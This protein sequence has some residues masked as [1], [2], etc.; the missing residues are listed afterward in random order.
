M[1]WAVILCFTQFGGGSHCLNFVEFRDTAP[2][3]GSEEKLL[4]MCPQSQSHSAVWQNTNPVLSA[5][6]K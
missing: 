1:F 6:S 2:L 5:T 4:Q 3:R